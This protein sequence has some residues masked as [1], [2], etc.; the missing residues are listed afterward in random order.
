MRSLTLGGG[1]ER[2]YAADTGIQ[3]FCDSLDRAAFTSGV[4]AFKEHHHAQAFLA[5]PFL[6][7]HKLDLQP[8]QF[9]KVPAIGSKS[10]GSRAGRLLLIFGSLDSLRCSVILLVIG[11]AM[12]LFI[13]S[14]VFLRR[15]RPINNGILHLAE[16]IN[17]EIFDLALRTIRVSAN[18]K[19][20]FRAPKLSEMT[21]P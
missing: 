7:L 18:S 8:A 3:R 13:F 16:S 20:N 19:F 14:F 17:F 12:F 15:D 5:D 10:Q 2:Y 11:L 9:V 21:G 4:A 1:G 6:Q